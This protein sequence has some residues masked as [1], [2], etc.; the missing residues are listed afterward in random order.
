MN[1]IYAAKTNHITNP[2]GFLLNPVVFSWKVRECRGKNQRCARILVAKDET[3][4]DV[5]WDTGEAKLDSLAVKAEMN[6]EP[7]TRY[8]WKVIVTTDADEVLESDVQFFETPSG[9][10]LPEEGGRYE[11]GAFPVSSFL[12]CDRAGKTRK[13]SPHRSRGLHRF[14]YERKTGGSRDRGGDRQREVMGI[15]F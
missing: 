12:G 13:G 9:H 4:A 6:L 10:L 3:F 11:N 5:L 1:Q 15:S 14:V 2:V 8:Y 7:C